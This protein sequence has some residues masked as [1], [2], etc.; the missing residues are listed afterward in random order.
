MLN[1]E[2]FLEVISEKD[3]IK[4]QHRM[5]YAN[6]IAEMLVQEKLKTTPQTNDVEEPYDEVNDDMNFFIYISQ[7]TCYCEKSR[8]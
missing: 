5:A 4:L 7:L 6:D 8:N 2:L 3:K 1:C